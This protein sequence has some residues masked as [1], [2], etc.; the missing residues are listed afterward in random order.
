MVGFL[1]SC[2]IFQSLIGRGEWH[3]ITRYKSLQVLDSVWFSLTQETK[4]KHMKIVQTCELKAATSE[5]TIY[6][7]V[8]VESLLKS[9]GNIMMKAAWISDEKARLVKSS[10]SPHPHL[11]K[12]HGKK[13]L[14]CCDNNCPMFKG[15]SLCF[16]HA[17]LGQTCYC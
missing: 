17:Y 12:T 4:E 6:L 7:G 3:F 13:R 2:H 8:P 5:L 14:Y 9:E 1:R 10:S 11:V 16:A 15:F